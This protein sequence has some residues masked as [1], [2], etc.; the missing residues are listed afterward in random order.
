MT[1]GHLKE[2]FRCLNEENS[3]HYDPD[4]VRKTIHACAVMHNFR[5]LNV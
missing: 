1:N 2:A 3:L 4:T 5:K